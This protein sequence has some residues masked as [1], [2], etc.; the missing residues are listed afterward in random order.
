MNVHDYTITIPA[1][2]HIGANGVHT[3]LDWNSHWHVFFDHLP[4]R[5]L[6]PA[7]QQQWRIRAMDEAMQLL[8]HAKMLGYK[9]H[10]YRR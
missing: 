3:V 5:A 8:Y 10:P 9:I 2:K 1:D 7:E 6:S 4:D